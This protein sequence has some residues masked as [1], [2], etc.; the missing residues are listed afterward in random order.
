MGS[1]PVGG[2]IF[3]ESGW[4]E[5]IPEPGQKKGRQVKAAFFETE[6]IE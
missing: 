3:Q 5:R 6:L 2:G 4:G 1:W